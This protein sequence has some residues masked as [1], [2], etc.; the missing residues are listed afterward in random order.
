MQD[1]FDFENP[2]ASL[3][4]LL[5]A[6]KLISKLENDHWRNQK[7]IEIQRIIEASTG[8]FLE[9][10]SKESSATQGEEIQLGIDICLPA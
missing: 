3:G 1:E 8:L 4:E 2:S 10:V 6:Y 9:A 5:K 7:M